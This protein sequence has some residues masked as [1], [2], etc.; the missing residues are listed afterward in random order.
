VA[1]SAS[2]SD[3]PP[4]ARNGK[5]PSGAKGKKKAAAASKGTSPLVWAGAG[6]GILLLVG[7]SVGVAFMAGSGGSSGSGTGP[8]GSPE[9]QVLARDLLG[10]YQNDEASANSEFLGNTLAVSGLAAKF[11]KEGDQR[12]VELKGTRGLA[13]ITVRCQFRFINENDLNGISIGEPIM[14]R[15]Q[16]LGKSGNNVMLKDCR[17]VRRVPSLPI[18]SDTP[19]GISGGG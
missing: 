19:V 9:I 12:Y 17:F 1:R 7:V 10:K 8:G 2:D 13:V 15:G 16:C 18:S 14:V 3:H 11:A 5:R 4:A 6:V